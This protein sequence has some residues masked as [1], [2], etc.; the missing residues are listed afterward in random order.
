LSPSASVSPSS[1]VSPSPSA[2]ISA[3][4]SSSPSPS[5]GSSPSASVSL[6][7][8]ASPS[9]SPSRSPSASTS[10]S[11]SASPSQ[12]PGSGLYSK[13]VLVSLP[14]TKNNLAIIYGEDDEIAVSEDDGV[15]VALS[16]LSVSY[17][18][19]QFRIIHDTNKDNVCIKVNLQ[20]SLACSISPVY[21]QV[22]NVST[23]LWETL[24]TNLTSPADTDFTLSYSIES[25]IS[26]Y[27]DTNYEIAVRVYQLNNAG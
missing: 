16:G 24:A 15:R 1:S 5:G 23:G 25:N 19:H 7:P 4:P 12:A 11:A 17:L 13:E 8:S 9:L 21:L 6:S 10:P 20:V 3:S 14:I 2:S 22:W 26:N 27:F 18:V